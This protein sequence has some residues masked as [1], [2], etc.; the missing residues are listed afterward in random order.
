MITEDFYLLRD[1]YVKVTYGPL[2][3]VIIKK[4]PNGL[5]SKREL[6]IGKE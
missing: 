1:D 2:N 4:I 3:Q 5:V 6:A